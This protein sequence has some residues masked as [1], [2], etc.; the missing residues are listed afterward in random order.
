MENNNELYHYGVLGMKWG[1]RRYQNKDGSLT[2][3]GKKKISKEYKKTSIKVMN[4]L[5]K[6]HNHMY[7][8]S[9]N[10]AAKYMNE[11]GIDKFNAE[12]RKKYG[13]KYPERDG[14]MSDYDRI[15]QKH[16][17][18]NMNQSL[19][20]FYQ[21]NKNYQKGKSLVDKYNMTEWDE[22]AKSNEM[23]IEEIRKAI[24]N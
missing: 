5:S 16:V 3:A 7:A 20:D 21:N 2:P 10:K 1:V 22:L 19:N 9:Y 18:K 24:N 14:Y 12:Q 15:F 6:N 23:K 17:I 4:D 8:Q 13:D 11:G